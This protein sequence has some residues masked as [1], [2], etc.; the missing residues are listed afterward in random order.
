MITINI[1]PILLQL[2]HFAL[3]WYGLIVATAIAVGIGVALSE[4]RRKGLSERQFADAIPWLI[5]GGLIGAR[6]FH[7]IDHLADESRANLRSSIGRNGAGVASSRSVK[8]G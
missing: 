5:V 7:V 1:D 4:A 6:L 8:C 2:G 3:R